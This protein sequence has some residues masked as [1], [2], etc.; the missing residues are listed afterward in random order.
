MVK[1]KI[2][3]NNI[4]FSE[5]VNAKETLLRAANKPPIRSCDYD[6]KKY[7]KISVLTDD[8]KIDVSLKPKDVVKVKWLCESDDNPIALRVEINGE[9]V[10][11]NFSGKKLLN[12]LSRYSK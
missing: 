10:R 4:S 2:L 8:A 7:S 9:P 5:F 12:W 1:D 6:I 11:T 3:N